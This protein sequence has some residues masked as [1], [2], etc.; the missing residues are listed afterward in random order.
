MSTTRL[1]RPRGLLFAEASLVLLGI[2]LV[3]PDGGAIPLGLFGIP[4][5]V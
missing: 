4:V 2:V 1:L 5:L 3:L